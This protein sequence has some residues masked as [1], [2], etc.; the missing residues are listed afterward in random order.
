MLA[1]IGLGEY[2]ALAGGSGF[3]SGFIHAVSELSI[4]LSYNPPL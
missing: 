3:V 2:F 4:E 1:E